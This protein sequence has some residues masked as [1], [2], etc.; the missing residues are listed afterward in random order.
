MNYPKS[1][2]GEFIL[3]TRA[4]GAGHPNLRVVADDVVGCVAARVIRERL[5]WGAAS[6]LSCVEV[7]RAQW[8]VWGASRANERRNGGH[9]LLGFRGRLA[10]GS[11][12]YCN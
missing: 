9:A 12:E 8:Q 5:P 7:Q 6:R 11:L 4:M 1:E 3:D 10:G 2:A